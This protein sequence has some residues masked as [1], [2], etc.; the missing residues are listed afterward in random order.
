MLKLA[1][2]IHRAS[3]LSDN[4]RSEL[5]RLATK[6][7]AF[8]RKEMAARE[9]GLSEDDK[10]EAQKAHD[11]FKKAIEPLKEKIGKKFPADVVWDFHPRWGRRL[12]PSK[13]S[14]KKILMV[15]ALD[16]REVRV[17]KKRFKAKMQKAEINDMIKSA[18]AALSEAQKNK[19]D[20][21]NV[22]DGWLKSSEGVLEGAEKKY[23]AKINTIKNKAMKRNLGR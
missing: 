6:V 9:K 22:I 8:T 19:S 7:A 5:R 23:K 17:L 16:P 21:A 13:K 14:K 20:A 2:L 10:K 1:K 15:N 3:H 18:Q 11:E 12:V 4:H